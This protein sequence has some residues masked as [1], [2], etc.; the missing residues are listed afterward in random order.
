MSRSDI[1][2]R[3]LDV[4]L[5]GV[6]FI[7][8]L[9]VLVLITLGTAISLRAWPFFTQTRIGVGGVPFR[10]FKLRTLPAQTPR[11][12]S[13]YE[14]GDLRIP[15]FSRLLRLTHLDELPQLLLVL[16]GK[17]SLV[18]PRPEMPY[19]HQAMPAADAA[20]RTSI[21]PGCTG[22][23]QISEH[24]TAMIYEHPE[25]DAYYVANRG[26]R[27]DL[28]ILF[29]TVLLV[30][31][32]MPTSMATLETLPGWVGSPVRAAR[33]PLDL[34]PGHEARARRRAG[35]TEPVVDAQHV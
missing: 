22:L 34:R 27:F 10:F 25:L 1:Y 23:W 28:W 20:T 9:P 33:E 5:S 17:M 7:L 24:C 16:S 32:P 13:K 4:V 6:L 35:L 12:A 14:L 11:Y 18:G 31:R 3:V 26:V 30:L 2:K 21:R 8:T 19:L 29:R 15:R